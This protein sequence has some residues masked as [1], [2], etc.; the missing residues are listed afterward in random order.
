MT[1][2]ELGAAFEAARKAGEQ[3]YR[4][5]IHPNATGQRIIA[6]TLLPVIEEEIRAG[7]PRPATTTRGTR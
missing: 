7:A 5:F 4:D 6:T 1:P 3:P 2:V